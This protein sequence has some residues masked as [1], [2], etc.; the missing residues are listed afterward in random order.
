MTYSLSDFLGAISWKSRPSS[1]TAA[2]T[3]SSS[4]TTVP[5]VVDQ[6]RVAVSTS[7]VGTPLALPASSLAGNEETEA[8]AE[9]DAGKP[10]RDD[11]VRLT[12]NPSAT[13]L[14]SSRHPSASSSS[15]SLA[16]MML[17]LPPPA[18]SAVVAAG[19]GGVGAS[20]TTATTFPVDFDAEY[21]RQL[22]VNDA[23]TH[24]LHHLVVY[25]APGDYHR[26]HSP[27]DWTVTFRRHFPGNKCR[28]Y[29]IVYH[30]Y[31]F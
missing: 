2:A 16:S 7:I 8:E 24:K 6:Q 17:T 13:S 29:R 20:T 28:A 23:T 19:S 10:L 25:L 22:C 27:A 4:S 12:I 21:Q 5:T 30:S 3:S 9:T 26:F 11:A 15:S 31:P 18:S 1:T 14:T